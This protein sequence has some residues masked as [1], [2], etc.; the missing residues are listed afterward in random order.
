MA[1]FISLGNLNMPVTKNG[2]SPRPGQAFYF[3]DIDHVD[4][5]G[6][7]STSTISGTAVAVPTFETLGFSWMTQCR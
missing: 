6:R 4:L 5:H 7:S 1:L 2:T 3:P